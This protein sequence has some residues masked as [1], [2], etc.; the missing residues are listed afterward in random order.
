MKC[1]GLEARCLQLGKILGT[2]KGQ[3]CLAH[4]NSLA[5]LSKL[6][7]ANLLKG[8]SPEGL[9]SLGSCGQCGLGDGG[10]QRAGQG[11]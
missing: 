10:V 1:T 4:I 9:V 5:C 3:T 2:T 11:G 6:D 8:E 7:M